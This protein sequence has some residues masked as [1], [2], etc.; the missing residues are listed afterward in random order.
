MVSRITVAMVVLAIL[1]SACGPRTQ[2]RANDAQAASETSSP[3][4]DAPSKSATSAGARQD[5]AFIGTVAPVQKTRSLRPYA[6]RPVLRAVQADRGPGPGYDRVVFEFTGD[7]VPG[8]RV[9]YTTR[10]V[11]R[12]GSGDP[13]SVA[14]TGRLLV[15]F[16]PAQAHDE[17]GNPT[18]PL[19][20]RQSTPELTA[21]REMTL[22][23]DFEG[24]VEWVLG[25]TAPAAYR[26]S[27]LTGPARVV[28]DVSW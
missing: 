5:P 26:V 2:P 24:Q 27:E 28:L 12:C 14:G 25:I 16:E 17:H 10:P 7:S 3:P 6:A 11:Q 4:G 18:P 15:R 23:C 20:A 1:T 8:Y 21:V 13:V 22:I 19:A 9:E